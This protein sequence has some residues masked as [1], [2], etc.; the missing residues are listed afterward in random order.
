MA[1]PK[2]KTETTTLKMTPEIKALWALCAEQEHRSLT[3]MF[4]IMVMD[5]AKKLNIALPKSITCPVKIQKI[6]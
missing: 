2:T 3:N 4:D 1:R 5:Y 6:K